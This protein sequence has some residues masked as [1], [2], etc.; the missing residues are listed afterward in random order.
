MCIR[1]RFQADI[2]DTAVERPSNTETTALGAAYLAGL[3]V[4]FYDAN[5]LNGL[6]EVDQTFTPQMLAEERERL[7]KGWLKAV[8]RTR[9]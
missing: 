9:S 2:L 8:E 4:G 3:A 5:T 7:Y 1:D 6:N